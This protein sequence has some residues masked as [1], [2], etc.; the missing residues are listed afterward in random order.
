M[1]TLADVAPDTDPSADPLAWP[2]SIAVDIGGTFTDL[3]LIDGSGRLVVTKV[4]SVPADPSQGVLDAVD[5][6]AALNH[7]DPEQILSNCSRFV[8]GSTVAT[9]AVLERKLAPVGL[10]T[11]AGFRD[12]LE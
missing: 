9:N 11:T 12:A 8:H 4:P 3:V 10:I 6:I 1:A 7:L 5:R 2:C